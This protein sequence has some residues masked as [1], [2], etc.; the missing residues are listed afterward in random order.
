MRSLEAKHWHG[1]T[2]SNNWLLSYL[3]K[4]SVE[5]HQLMCGVIWLDKSSTN[6]GI[7]TIAMTMIYYGMSNIKLIENHMFVHAMHNTSS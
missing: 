5:V 7:K 6:L 4:P 3:Q 1:T 2:I